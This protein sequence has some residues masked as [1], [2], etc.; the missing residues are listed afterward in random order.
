MRCR[1]GDLTASGLDLRAERGFGIEYFG[2]RRRPAGR[3]S[4][5]PQVTFPVEEEDRSNK[6][7]RVRE[8]QLEAKPFLRSV[9]VWRYAK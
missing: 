8:S 2:D 6:P 1:S 4:D 9:P 3:R 7:T 5:P